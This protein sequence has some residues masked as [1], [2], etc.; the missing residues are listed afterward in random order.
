MLFGLI[1]P[2]ASHNIYPV[3]LFTTECDIAT[4]YTS[5]RQAVFSVGHMVKAYDT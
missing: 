3:S 4:H 1:G 5:P 2:S